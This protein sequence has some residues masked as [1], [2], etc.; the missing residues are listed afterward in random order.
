[1]KASLFQT[2]RWRRARP[3]PVADV[4]PAPDLTG[5]PYVFVIGFNKTATTTL[6][7]FFEGNGL[8]AVH[9]DGNQ[10]A[11]TMMNNCLAD[12]PILHGYDHR[13]RVFS[14]MIA[15]TKRI[16]LEANAFFRILDVDYPDAFFLFNNRDTDAWIASR[17]R[18][19]CRRYNCT[20]VELEM[21]ILNT[22]DPRQV[23]ATWRREKHAFERDVRDYFAGHPRF[24][25]FDITDAEA[26]VKIARLLG[27]TMDQ[28]L[29]GHYRT[30]G[31]NGAEPAAP[32][33]PLAAEVRRAS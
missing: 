8:P 24:L 17:W 18:K 7:H 9:W 21:G 31:P 14:D 6:H 3:A 12:R 32:T 25:E 5:L 22:R 4:P 2:F 27:R 20:N 16:R 29:W 15:Q 26:P 1:M 19:P 13:Y 23:E 28:S 33:I 10:L 11:I 30:N